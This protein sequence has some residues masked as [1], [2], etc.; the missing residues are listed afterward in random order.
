MRKSASTEWKVSAP[1]AVNPVRAAIRQPA[2]RMLWKVSSR[3]STSR[4]V[5]RVRSARK[6]SSGSSLG[7]CLP[8]KPPPGSGAKTRTWFSGS[9]S[10]EASVRCS[11]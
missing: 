5:R 8:P 9:P 4:Q 2:R 1:S 10:T 6:A 3:E 7:F 11:R